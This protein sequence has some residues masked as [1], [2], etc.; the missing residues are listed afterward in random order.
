MNSG[1]DFYI[2]DNG[3]RPFCVTMQKKTLITKVYSKNRRINQTRIIVRSLRQHFEKDGLVK[4]DDKW[5]CYDSFVY[6][7][8]PHDVLIG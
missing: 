3:G 4:M 1:R 5:A 8:N 2:H 6:Y 7:D